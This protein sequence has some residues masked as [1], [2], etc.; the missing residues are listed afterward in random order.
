K[1]CN[2]CIE[3]KQL[4][5]EV[6]LDTELFYVVSSIDPSPKHAGMIIPKRHIETPFEFN[7]E[8]W[9]AL[10]DIIMQTKQMLDAYNPDGYNLGWNVGK[11]GGQH[12]MHAHLHI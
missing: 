9:A 12:V 1:D 11:A 2:F 8:E 5:G 6:W 10:Q 7:T 4:K 3:N